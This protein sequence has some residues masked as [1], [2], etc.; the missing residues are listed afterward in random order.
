MA[1]TTKKKVEQVDVGVE[2]LAAIE[3][4]AKERGIKKEVLFETVSSAILVAAKDQLRFNRK[5]NDSVSVSVEI[6]KETGGYCVFLNKEVVEEVYDDLK[7]ISVED[8]DACFPN[9]KHEI[10]DICKFE[11]KIPAFGRI[12]AQKAMQ[13]LTQKLREEERRELYEVY[14]AKLDHVVTGRISFESR[15]N[16]MISLGRVDAILPENEQI[17]GESMKR[18]KTLKTYVIKVENTSKGPKITVSRTHPELVCSLFEEEVTEIAD[19]TVEI[20]SIAREAGSRTKIAVQSYDEN[21]DPVGSCVGVNGERVNAVVNELG[22]EKIDIVPW[23]DDPYELIRNALSPSKVSSVEISEN[24]NGDFI[25]S[26]V[27]PDDQLSLAIGKEGQNARLAAKL[28][29]YKID[30][31]SESQDQEADTVQNGEE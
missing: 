15:G 30:I 16:C 26:V 9:E 8:A 28:T 2:I 12:A 23:S 18:G 6:S 20:I 29:G 13:V 17:I 10:G 3:E 19:G 25:A 7:E 31:K 24:E 14:A 22:G 21:V 11:Q 5:E 27:V 4:M 1:R